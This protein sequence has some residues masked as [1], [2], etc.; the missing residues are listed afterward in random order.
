M[1]RCCDVTLELQS[2]HAGHLYVNHKTGRV[3]K[4]V[5]FQET[6]ARFKNCGLITKRLDEQFCGPANGLIIIDYRDQIAGHFEKSPSEAKV[7]LSR[8]GIYWV[9][10]DLR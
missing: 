4:L 10:V 3:E 6:L 8:E 9:L 1:P 7:F 5:G 2:V